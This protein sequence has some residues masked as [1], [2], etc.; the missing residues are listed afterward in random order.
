VFMWDM[1]NG[2]KLGKLSEE[3]LGPISCL[4]WISEDVNAGELNK[5]P[6]VEAGES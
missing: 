1:Q 4:N 2:R 5:V 3:A 6:G